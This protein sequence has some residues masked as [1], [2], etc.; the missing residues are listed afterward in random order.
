MNAVKISIQLDPVRDGIVAF[1]NA[2]KVD[3]RRGIVIGTN[4]KHRTVNAEEVQDIIDRL[5]ENS[6]GSTVG[7]YIGICDSRKV[8]TVDGTKYL[9]GSMLIVKCYDSNLFMPVSEDDIAKIVIEFGSRIITLSAGEE[10]F[11]AYEL[12]L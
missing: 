6:V 12:E 3:D 7:D 5:D 2:V 8:L 11:S 4:G 10:D 9:V 1:P